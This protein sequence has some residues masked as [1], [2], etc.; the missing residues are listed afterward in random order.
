MQLRG[1]I[2]FDAKVTSAT[3]S[4]TDRKWTVTTSA[5]HR[6]SAKYLF[7]CT[8]LLHKTNTPRFPGLENYKGTVHHSGEW[9]A[10][11]AIDLSGQRVCVV[12]AGATGV[13]IVSTL[14]KTAGHLTSLVRRPSYCMPMSN[15]TLSPAEV[16]AW[17]PMLPNIL[18][19]SRQTATGFLITQPTE[20]IWSV[21]EAEREAF[22]EYLWQAGGFAFA[23]GNYA[24]A[25]V[26]TKVNKI[27]YDFWCKKTRLRI[28]DP[29]KRDIL[30][31][32]EPPYPFMTKR[33]PLEHDY[34][35]VVNRESVDVVDIKAT[36]IKEFTETGVVFEG[37]GGCEFEHLIM[38]TGFESFSGS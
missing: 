38:A 8:G 15:R 2:D 19:S 24:E 34:Y 32:L 9:P 18:G 27:A 1:A 10:E 14:G 5:G 11:N 26:D 21:P 7:S 33:T 29:R 22:Y 23:L 31:P 35:D 20:A 3:W 28:T 12:G 30:A 17:K 16:R 4:E 25:A 36:P 6:I 37:G 13:Q